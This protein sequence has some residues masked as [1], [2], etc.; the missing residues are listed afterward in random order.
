VNSGRCKKNVKNRAVRL[1]QVVEN[2][3]K[4]I[5]VSEPTWN[6]ESDE[7]NVDIKC[8]ARFPTVVSLS[9]LISERNGQELI[10]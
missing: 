5:F 7:I 6:V 9:L 8:E 4:K 2:L 1:Q 10:E 3:K